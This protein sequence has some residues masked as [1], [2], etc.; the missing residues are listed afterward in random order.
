MI[1]T[2]FKSIYSNAFIRN[3]I[4][5]YDELWWNLVMIK[6][7]NLSSC[8]FMNIKSKSNTKFSKQKYRHPF[9]ISVLNITLY[10]LMHNPGQNIWMIRI[11]GKIVNLAK[12]CYFYQKTTNKQN[13]KLFKVKFWPKSNLQNRAYKK[14]FNLELI[15]NWLVLYFYWSS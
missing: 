14:Q 5:S 7:S 15:H 4:Y 12:K 10:H 9:S 6:N 2:F 13:W 11:S 8:W 1:Y 3:I